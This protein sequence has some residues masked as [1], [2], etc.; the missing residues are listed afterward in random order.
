MKE[1]EDEYGYEHSSLL[2]YHPD[3][4]NKA[5]SVFKMKNIKAEDFVG[6]KN[7][8]SVD[9]K[10]VREMLDETKEADKTNSDSSKGKGFVVIF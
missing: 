9:K 10:K 1:P 2:W 7:L 6:Y 5:M 4:F 8:K 3:C